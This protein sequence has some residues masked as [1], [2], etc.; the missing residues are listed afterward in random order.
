MSAF[1]AGVRG[2]PSFIGSLS[3]RVVQAAPR[4]FRVGSAGVRRAFSFNPRT[5]AAP[6]VRGKAFAFSILGILSSVTWLILWF[7]ITA[8]AYFLIPLI[9]G[10]LAVAF[11]GLSKFLDT[12]IGNIQNSRWYNKPLRAFIFFVK[13]VAVVLRA[14]IQHIILFTIAH[15]AQIVVTMVVAFIFIF[16]V[17]RHLN[18]TVGLLSI[19]ADIAV[20]AYNLVGAILEFS[21]QLFNAVNP[22]LNFFIKW[23]VEIALHIYDGL[24]FT[25][26]NF[27][28]NG[29]RLQET[30]ALG[31]SDAFFALVDLFINSL[32]Y[33]G[34]FFLFLATTIIDL[35]FQLNMVNILAFILDVLTIILTKL[36]CAIG[37][38]V[39]TIAE[40]GY[41][42]VNDFFIAG[43]NLVFGFLGVTIPTIEFGCTAGQ[44]SYLGGQCGGSIPSLD[45]PGI[46]HNLIDQRRRLRVS[47]EDHGDQFSEWF[48]D[49]VVHRTENKSEACPHARSSF[50]PYGHALNM[51]SLDTHD[52]YEVC[53]R[54][55]LF[56]ACEDN[57]QY[58]IGSCGTAKKNMTTRD[59]RRRL[60]GFFESK[61]FLRS[62]NSLNSMYTTGTSMTRSQ[63][64]D[65]LKDKVGTKFTLNGFECDLSTPTMNPYEIVVNTACIVGRVWQ[66]YSD[67]DNNRRRL[68]EEPS[69]PLIKQAQ[70]L[71]PSLDRWKHQS[72]LIKTHQ[73]D[74]DHHPTHP[75]VR[76]HPLFMLRHSM[77]KHRRMLQDP[78]E[79]PEKKFK[80]VT[81]HRLPP[82]MYFFDDVSRIPVHRTRSE[83]GRRLDGIVE[84]DE[85]ERLCA[86][87]EQ[88]V[89]NY[90]DCEDAESYGVIS[91]MIFYLEQGVIITENIDPATI[92]YQIIDCWRSYATN[93]EVDPLS[94]ESIGKSEEEKLNECYW[95]FPMFPPWTYTHTPW[96]FSFRST[97][98][99]SCTAVSEQF[100]SCQCAMYYDLPS[101]TLPLTLFLSA[102]FGFIFLNG[103]IFIKNA[104]ILLVGDWFGVFWMT[105]FP[106]PFFGSWWSRLFSLYDNNIE[107]DVYFMC[108]FLH[109][110]SGLTVVIFIVIAFQLFKTSFFI[111]RF[112]LTGGLSREDR[113]REWNVKWM[114][115]GRVWNALF[116][117]S[118]VVA[119]MQKRHDE[120]EDKTNTLAG[121]L[122]NLENN[123]LGR[124]GVPRK[125]E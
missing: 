51:A 48:D 28:F 42:I 101:T 17:E 68:S 91:W 26:E 97:I 98:A 107:R 66:M 124:N 100:K 25:S 94:F 102:D 50:H 117:T 55:V 54:G 57:E 103:L 87:M 84:C 33:I 46:F 53:V 16:M 18:D 81:V 41:F 76:K 30:E 108:Q 93:P 86:N 114:R 60:D 88:C 5:A 10:I 67:L 105:I 83:H 27:G 78:S 9:V 110:G 3:S 36:Y 23:N 99:S 32:L 96:T 115:Y 37:G 119:D 73:K 59:A 62:R 39:C 22:L 44:L 70:E 4:L 77:D 19:L 109:I 71:I 64:L 104:W 49:M 56:E 6:L 45:P 12:Y 82:A 123:L 31:L 15:I 79:V 65:T 20:G 106:E 1:I 24:V 29:R 80:P 121:R 69:H 125:K 2:I 11:G 120:T 116:D 63:V 52:C 58:H 75:I 34:A 43:L 112:L 92:M 61:T 72:R 85:G 40:I 14:V 38:G 74:Y 122:E 7:G 113:I 35:F 89:V 95:C 90:E 47:C 118:G 13:L 111:L 21:S 8:L